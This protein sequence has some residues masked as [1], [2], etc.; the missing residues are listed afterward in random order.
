MQG[1]LVGETR[2]QITW[3]TSSLPGRVPGFPQGTIHHLH[4]QTPC[5][6]P[7]GEVKAELWKCPERPGYPRS[8]RSYLCLWLPL[9]LPPSTLFSLIFIR[10]LILSGLQY[11]SLRLCDVLVVLLAV[12][13]GLSSP[14]SGTRLG[15]LGAGGAGSGSAIL[16]G[17]KLVTFS[18]ALITRCPDVTS[19]SVSR[20]VR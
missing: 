1:P 19:L 5:W 20:P 2:H 17:K 13:H 8:R 12:A 14:G 4:T 3:T 16:W 15:G 11:A 6:E 7:S 9:L 10:S 18:L